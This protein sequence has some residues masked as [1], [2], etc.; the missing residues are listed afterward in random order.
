MPV[1]RLNSECIF[2]PPQLADKSGMLAVGGDLS[3]ERLLLA[4][5]NG[6]FPW[7]SDGE[8]ICWWAP[9][10]R[11]VLFTD[12]LHISKSLA[13]TRRQQRF[14]VTYDQAFEQVIGNCATTPRHDQDGT[15]ITTEMQA[16]YIKMH[17]LG[18]AHSVESW[19]DGQLAGGLYG[20][21]IGRVFFGES[22]F[23][24]LPD[25]SKV[26]FS[27]LVLTLREQGVKLIDCQ[28]HTDYL[29]SFGARHIPLPLFLEELERSAQPF[30]QNACNHHWP[31]IL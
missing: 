6:I 20:M 10:P 23:S 26:A 28:V 24:H 2:P 13:K 17:R 1:F 5:I 14:T 19:Q 25:S 30:V 18:I 29:E 3:P 4:Y 31:N 7:Y 22:M 16:A 8:P 21:Q 15:W 27:T 9:N 12:E 11:F